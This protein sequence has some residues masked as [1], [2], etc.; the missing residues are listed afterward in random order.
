MAIF[1]E[2]RVLVCTLL[3]K[4]KKSEARLAQIETRLSEISINENGVNTAPN[5][6]EKIHVNFEA[7]NIKKNDENCDKSEIS[8]EMSEKLIER[9]TDI[10]A[11]YI[12]QI[13]K[14]SNHIEYMEKSHQK[15][16]DDLEKAIISYKNE[17]EWYK[18]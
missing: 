15:I 2:I 11:I 3:M 13:E 1:E 8:N 4:L 16:V 18:E 6:E 17:L 9:I 10:S 5:S 7:P 14:L 12:K